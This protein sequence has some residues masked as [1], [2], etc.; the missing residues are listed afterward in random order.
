MSRLALHNIFLHLPTQTVAIVLAALFTT[1]QAGALPRQTSTVDYGDLDLVSWPLQPTPAPLFPLDLLRRQ[2]PNTICGYIGGNSALPATCSAGSHCVLDQGHGFIGCCPDNGPCTAGIYT[3]CVDVNSPPQTV[4]NPYIYTC[5]GSDVCYKN[6]FA[7][8]YNQYGCGTASNLGTTVQTSIQGITTALDLPEVSAPLTQDVSSLSEPTTIGS[9]AS[10]SDASS[11]S[12]SGASTSSNSI[13][14]SQF[15]ATDSSTSTSTSKT[16]SSKS[17]T[18]S[19]STSSTT[20]E[21]ATNG[22]GGPAAGDD[23]NRNAVI[24]GASVGSVAGVAL[25]GIAA[26]LIWRRRR[27]NR[28]GPGRTPAGPGTQYISPMGNHGAAFAPLPTWSDEDQYQYGQDNPR[29]SNESQIRMVPPPLHQH[30]AFH[31]QPMMGVGTGLTPVA[32][33]HHEDHDT[34]HRTGHGREIDNF[35]Q[36]Y[37]NAGIGAMSSEEELE[38]YPL[39]NAAATNPQGTPGD[40]GVAGTDSDDM[41]QPLT[42]SRGGHRPLWQQNRHQS[43]NMIWM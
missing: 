33:E 21:P 7:G 34:D 3:G 9:A 26:C 6:E 4:V 43:R 5:Q 32:E 10:T 39:A 12:S 41:D 30:P 8:G 22:P 36:A 24:I 20:G 35:S 28:Q 15:S 27:N 11:A 18:S 37:S 29:R 14:N 40:R 2:I 17:Q 25:L 23:G 38:R 16:Q 13:T 19:T 31:Q 1:S 42:P